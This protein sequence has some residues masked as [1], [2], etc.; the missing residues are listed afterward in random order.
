MS[1]YKDTGTN[2]YISKKETNSTEN[3]MRWTIQYSKVVQTYLESTITQHGYDTQKYHCGQYSSGYDNSSSC[4]PTSS[5]SNSET[6]TGNEFRKSF[7]IA[8]PIWSHASVRLFNLFQRCN[9]Q[10][11][12]SFVGQRHICGFSTSVIQVFT[13]KSIYLIKVWTYDFKLGYLQLQVNVT[14]NNV[15]RRIEMKS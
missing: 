13:F 2:F 4:H 6:G 8:D 12:L 10:W 7:L 11:G 3:Q 5:P 14:N 1:F 15:H 9:K